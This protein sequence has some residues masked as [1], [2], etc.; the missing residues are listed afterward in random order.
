[1]TTA[2]L[3]DLMA[4]ADDAGMAVWLDGD[5]EAVMVEARA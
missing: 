4:R 5:S 1:M 2:R 3:L